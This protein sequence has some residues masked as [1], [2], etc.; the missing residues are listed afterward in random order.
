MQ[1]HGSLAILNF[2]N[3]YIKDEAENLIILKRHNVLGPR[4]ICL[5]LYHKG[6]IHK[7]RRQARGR[8]ICQMSM[9]VYVDKLGHLYF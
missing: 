3:V 6:A 2:E 9:L 4:R 5:L 7:L 8:R 1:H